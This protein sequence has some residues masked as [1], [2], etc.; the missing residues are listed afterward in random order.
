[1]AIP[2][3]Y[4]HQ[5]EALK[6]CGSGKVL[7]GS[8][9]SG[10]SLTALAWY[11]LLAE[12][13]ISSLMGEEYIPM[14][15]NL[16]DL[17]I[18][19]TALKRDR[20]EWEREMAPFLLFTEGENRLYRNTVK[21]DSWNNI[22]KYTGVENAVFIFDEQRVIGSGAWVRSFL[23]IAKHNQWILLSATPGDSW[24]DYIPLFI[25]NGFYRSRYQF[26]KEHVVYSKYAKFPKIERYLDEEKLERLRDSIL[27]DMDFERGVRHVHEDILVDYDREAYKRIEKQRWDVYKNEPIQNYGAFSYALKRAANDHKSRQRA[28]LDIAEQTPKLILFYNFDYELETLREL[29]WPEGTVVAEWNGHRH[30]EIPKAERW[31]YLV[32]YAAGAEG[33]N[34]VETDTVL[35]Y[36]QN[37]SYRTMT[38]AA[39]RIDR[40]NTPF[41]VLHYWHLKSRSQIDLDM[42]RAYRE[43]KDFN[44]RRNIQKRYP[45]FEE[46]DENERTETEQADG[47]DHKHAGA[48]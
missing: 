48:A 13:D 21:V 38:Q 14:D 16:P 44:D 9:G 47:P 33:W 39:G 6:K 42:D 43:K 37:Y 29:P 36:S 7:C 25:A 40:L 17:Y 22:A 19:T 30:Q 8:V 34:C 5:L 46:V 3:L 20:F 2:P 28:A 35:F 11:Y 24:R 1:M 23:K 31:V 10:K 15:D 27:I 18:I 26:E 12:G 4:E 41:K 45:D 32:N